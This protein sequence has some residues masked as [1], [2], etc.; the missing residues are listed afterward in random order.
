MIMLDG[1][2]G[3]VSEDVLH[4][5]VGGGALLAAEVVERLHAG[6]DVVYDRD[7]DDDG[8]GIAPHHHDGDDVSGAVLGKVAGQ[9]WWVRDVGIA[10]GEPTEQTE[11]AGEDVDSHDGEDQLS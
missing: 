9:R 10:T 7:D 6:H 5:G 4:H 2:L 8:D 1:D 3:K 11:Q